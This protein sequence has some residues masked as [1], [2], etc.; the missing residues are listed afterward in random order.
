MIISKKKDFI[1]NNYQFQASNFT[2]SLQLYKR[3]NKS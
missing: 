1:Q 3:E 2:A